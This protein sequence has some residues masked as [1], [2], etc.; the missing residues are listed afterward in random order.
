MFLVALIFV[1]YASLSYAL[2]DRISRRMTRWVPR[3]AGGQA[4]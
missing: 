4:S 1:V 2:F 3:S